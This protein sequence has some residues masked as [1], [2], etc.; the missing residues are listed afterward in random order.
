MPTIAKITKKGQVTIPSKIRNKLNSEIVEFTILED[1]IILRPVKSVAG[2]LSAYV[3]KDS[4]P[5]QEAREKSWTK[6]V[7]EHYGKK[8]RRR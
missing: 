8:A 5:F 4:V 2:A 3:K 6:A 7:E 1:Q